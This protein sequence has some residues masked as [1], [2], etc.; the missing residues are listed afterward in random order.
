L[1][2]EESSLQ[3]LRQAH[4][5]TQKRMAHVLGIARTACPGWNSAATC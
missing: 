4:K 1:I 2:A 5:L 3:E